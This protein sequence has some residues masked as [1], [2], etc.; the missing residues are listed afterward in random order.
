MLPTQLKLLPVDGV[1]SRMQSAEYVHYLQ[2]FAIW[3]LFD[4]IS[5]VQLAESEATT[6]GAKENWLNNYAVRLAFG[7]GYY[8]Y[9]FEI[10]IF[11]IFWKMLDKRLLNC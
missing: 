4:R 5:Q 1:R 11:R 10:S 6:K 8:I 2:F 7:F 3:D 9:L